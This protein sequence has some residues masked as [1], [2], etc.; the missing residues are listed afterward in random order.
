MNTKTFLAASLV[1]VFVVSMIMLPAYATAG[2]LT[3]T[4][5]DVEKG[6]KGWKFEIETAGKILPVG[7]YGYGAFGENGVIAVTTHGGVGPDSE[8]QHGDA[9]NPVFHTHIVQLNTGTDTACSSEIGVKSASFETVG[10]L[11]ISGKTVE[12]SKIPENAVGKLTGT[13]VSFNL[14]FEGSELCVYPQSLFTAEND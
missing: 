8:A 2:Y 5:A 3:I 6:K 9:S 7:T 12:V 14:G 4:S 1:T 13:V 10:K 11:E